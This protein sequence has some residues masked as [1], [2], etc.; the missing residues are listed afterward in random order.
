MKKYVLWLDESGDFLNETEKKKEHRKASLIGGVLIEKEK[1]EQI[2][3][4]EIID[5]GRNHAMNLSDSDKSDYILPILERLEKEYGAREIFFENA[6]YDEGDNSRDL[7]LTIMAEGLLQLLQRM[8]ANYGDVELK[9]TIAHRLDGGTDDISG[10]EYEHYLETA[11]ENKKKKQLIYISEDTKL[12]FDIAVASRDKRLQL[13]DFAC[14]TRLTRDSKAFGAADVRNRVR[15][16]HDTAWIFIMSEGSTLNRIERL[17]TKDYWADALIEYYTYYDLLEPGEHTRIKNAILNRINLTNY[18]LQKSEV[19]KLSAG[20]TA[21]VNQESDYEYMEKE[22]YRIKEDMIPLL[23]KTTVPYEQTYFNLLLL[24]ADVYL[25]EGNSNQ[26]RDTLEECKRIQTELG[27]S[28]EEVF[29]YY[30]LLEKCAV[31][32]INDMDYKKAD[33]YMDKACELLKGVMETVEKC[34][35]VDG[36]FEHIRSEYYGDALCMKLYAMMFMQHYEPELYEEM[37]RLSD[38]ALKQYSNHDGEL[39]RHRQYR[40]HIEMEAGN[41]EEAVKW[42][43]LSKGCRL[44]QFSR[45]ELQEFW[46][47]IMVTEPEI[48]QQFYLMYYLEIVQKAYET[49]NAYADMLYDSIR[50]H[51]IL[52][53]LEIAYTTADIKSVTEVDLT[54]VQKES[55]AGIYHPMEIVLWKL[56]WL[57]G[58]NNN[59]NAITY[60]GNALKACYRKIMII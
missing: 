54:L 18:R 48:S 20:I 37:V 44:V 5:S 55:T 43:T 13:A 33:E 7:Y 50:E 28:L 31:L 58:R 30:Q 52:Q 8:N 9:V 60:Y 19:K 39:E 40:S 1:A 12:L 34:P 41:I 4:E 16:L 45:E 35:A 59:T 29:S 27:N 2:D 23:Q 32:E 11:I 24:L 17:L 47:Q 49:S 22:L 53:E 36:R 25:R 21:M 6:S 3:L 10:A 14:N 51:Q 56:A 42:I 15:A 38:I 26:A 46:N 57:S